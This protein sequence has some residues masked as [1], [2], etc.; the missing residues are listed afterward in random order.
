MNITIINGIKEVKT[1][2]FQMQLELACVKAAKEHKV[3]LFTIED[4]DIKYCCGCFGC[5]VKTPGR[6]IYKDDMD[7]VLKSL[8]NSD[9]MLVVS[10]INAG[11][12]SS[13]AKKAMDRILPYLQPFIAIYDGESHHVPRYENKFDLGVLLLDEGDADSEAVGIIYDTFD[14]LAKNTHSPKV[15]KAM[16]NIENLSEVLQNEISGC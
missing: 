9:L 8:V 4:M 11:F 2:P 5:W 12:V 1:N 13:E 10:E 14:R 16:A 7:K 15:I 6:C 3:D